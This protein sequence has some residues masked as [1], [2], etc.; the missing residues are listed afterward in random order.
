MRT[1]SQTLGSRSFRAGSLQ[2]G[3]SSRSGGVRSFTRTAKSSHRRGADNS[4]P[5]SGGNAPRPT[6]RAL[7]RR[8]KCSWKSGI[9]LQRHSAIKPQRWRAC[10]MIRLVPSTSRPQFP[11]EPT[12]LPRICTSHVSQGTRHQANAAHCRCIRRRAALS[13]S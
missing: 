5:A 10:R 9:P 11:C 1:N 4:S 7:R 3:R 2:V 8:M 12:L 13:L 6:A